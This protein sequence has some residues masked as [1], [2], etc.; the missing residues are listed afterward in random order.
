MSQPVKFGFFKFSLVAD[1][2]EVVSDLARP[3]LREDI[4]MEH[5][6]YCFC[7]FSPWNFSC[8]SF[9]NFQIGIQLESWIAANPSC[10]CYSGR[11]RVV[12]IIYHLNEENLMYKSLSVIILTMAVAFTNVE[13]HSKTQRSDSSTSA[14]PKPILVSTQHTVT[15]EGNLIHYTATT[16]TMMLRNHKN[17]P[18]ALF[19]FTAY[20]ENGVKDLS[21]RPITFAYNGGPGSSS[22]WLM[23]GVLG[24]KRIVLNDPHATHPAPYKLTDNKYS[25]LDAT[26][27]VI[28]DPAGT[29]FSRAVGKKK[30][31]DFWG[32]KQDAKSVS[33]FIMQYIGKYD[34][35]NSPKFL[36]GES[37]GTTRS[38]AVADYL[39]EN[40]GIQLNGI[41]FES[42]VW[43]FETLAFTQGNDLPY[44]LYLPSYAAVAWYHNTLPSKPA[45][46]VPFLER[47]RKFARNEYANA[48]FKGESI[49]SSEFHDVVDSLYEFTGISKDYWSEADLKLS[50]PQFTA[51]L[52]RKKGETTGRL[53]ARFTGPLT[54]MIEQYSQYD[55]QIAKISPV[56][57]TDFL[58]Y[59]HNNL[60][61][62]SE[63]YYHIFAYNEKGFSWKWNQHGQTGF[64]FHDP[65]V[66]P[67]LEDVMSKDPY[68]N[69]LMLNGYFD[70]AT[71]FFATEY[72]VD[73][74]GDN[75]PNL[76]KR[77]HFKYFKSGHMIY[78]DP[79][80]L[81]QLHK[82]VAD[83]IKSM[84]HPKD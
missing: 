82:D 11:F 18:I 46:L 13:A 32:M 17:K 84:I 22:I 24:P 34:R 7:Y 48:I 58:Y 19:G 51:E 21:T 43:N 3:K 57:I 59:L 27:L 10:D 56:F 74:L 44:I 31:S 30:N 54:D 63:Y 12:S 37:Y 42:T 55:P 16:G 45:H 53:D 81:P 75:V 9:F 78:V 25:I 2:L 62:P 77:V 70:L 83:F 61:F 26:D 28:L 73:H 14:T 33:E 6:K 80:M 71:P 1:H 35:W 8:F 64:G 47:V 66:T 65:N 39:Y 68:L 72:T 40:D 29:G 79:K 15:I 69:I 50:E 5:P 4:V 52:L 49:D 76:L 60:K 38:A 36:F 41:I 20:T 67:S 23:M